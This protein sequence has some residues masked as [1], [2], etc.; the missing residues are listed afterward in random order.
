MSFRLNGNKRIVAIAKVSRSQ[1]R[2]ALDW[3]T[4]LELRR[5]T[6]SHNLQPTRPIVFST[7]WQVVWRRLIFSHSL[8]W[9]PIALICATG[10][11]LHN[12]NTWY[13]MERIQRALVKIASSKLPSIRIINTL[14]CSIIFHSVFT[15]TILIFFYIIF[16]NVTL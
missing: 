13:C 9:T 15:A 7:L 2:H 14:N 1:Y 8:F 16:K 6:V 12:Y 3:K 4:A 10:S 5:R 11:D